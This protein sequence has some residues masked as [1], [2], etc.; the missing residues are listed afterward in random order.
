VEKM[1]DG[2]Y[3]IF[4]LHQEMNHYNFLLGEIICITLK[5]LICG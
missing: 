2:L 1:V 3:C 5:Q 4:E